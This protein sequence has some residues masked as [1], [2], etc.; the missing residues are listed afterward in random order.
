MIRWTR[1]AAVVAVLAAAGLGLPAEVASAAVPVP[2]P[3]S[4]V[5]AGCATG[6]ITS[7]DG[8]LTPDGQASVT[9]RGWMRPCVGATPSAEFVVIYYGLTG[10]VITPRQVYDFTSLTEPTSFTDNVT[11]D[12]QERATVRLP[13]AICIAGRDLIRVDCVRVIYPGAGQAPVV[14]RIST[15][16][17]VVRK[18]VHEYSED[19]PGGPGCGN[20]V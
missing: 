3:T 17:P 5:P 11:K 6:E 16:D 10:G 18:G 9:T 13:Q 14:S 20:C 19:D 15:G 12:S 8:K 7:F 1:P 4:V 2:D